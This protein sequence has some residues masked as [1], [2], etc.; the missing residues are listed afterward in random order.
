MSFSKDGL[1]KKGE[2]GKRKW[3][4]WM[5]ILQGRQEKNPENYTEEE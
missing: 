4:T 3:K 5:P 2:K 1:S